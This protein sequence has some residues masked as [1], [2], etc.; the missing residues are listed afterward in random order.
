MIVQKQD[1]KTES[2]VKP[3]SFNSKSREL[4]IEYVGGGAEVSDQELLASLISMIGRPTQ[5]KDTNR[6]ASLLVD[7][8]DEEFIQVLIEAVSSGVPGEDLWLADYM[9]ALIDLLSETEDY[10]QV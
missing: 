10:Y 1:G 9:Y 8:G 3:M 7:I 2:N 5:I 4:A 6:F